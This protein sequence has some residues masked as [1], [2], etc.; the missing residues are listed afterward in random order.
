[1]SAESNSQ[2]PEAAIRVVRPTRSLLQGGAYQNSAS[3]DIRARFEKMKADAEDVKA[4]ADG[5]S[6][7]RMRRKGSK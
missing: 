2:K 4:W 1:M 6:V 3:T 7:L 5:T